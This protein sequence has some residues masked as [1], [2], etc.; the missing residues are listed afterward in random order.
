MPWRDIDAIMMWVA[1]TMAALGLDP[2]TDH[3]VILA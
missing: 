2:F 3:M 1:A